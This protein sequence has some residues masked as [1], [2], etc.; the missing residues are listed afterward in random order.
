[1]IFDDF[2]AK[3]SCNLFCYDCD[4][5]RFSKNQGG[6]SKSRI[7][8]IF[9]L[10]KS[11]E[12]REILEIAISPD[13]GTAFFVLFFSVCRGGYPLPNFPFFFAGPRGVRGVPSL[14]FFFFG[15]VGGQGVFCRS[16]IPHHGY[17]TCD[18]L[19]SFCTR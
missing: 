16:F 4:F 1:M 19:Q 13:S 7:S 9:Q 5:A 6:Y 15:G 12:N 3:K 14:F 8:A 17:F 10:G 2:K 11:T 18:I